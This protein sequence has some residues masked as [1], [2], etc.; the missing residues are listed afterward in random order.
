MLRP[1]ED[2]RKLSEVLLLELFILNP[3][4][5]PPTFIA[6]ST[7]H[8]V[9]R[10]FEALRTPHPVLRTLIALYLIRAVGGCLS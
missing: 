6:H 8:S 3:Y 2:D 5:A 7:P 4:S 10:T 9:L 1:A